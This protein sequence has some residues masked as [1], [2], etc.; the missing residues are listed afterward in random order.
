MDKL[1]ISKKEDFE[2]YKGK[3]LEPSPYIVIDQNRINEFADATNDHQWIHCDP[4]RAEKESP[5]GKTIAHGY[6]IVSLIPYMI[7]QIFDIQNY[8]EAINYEIINLKFM[9]PVPVNGEIRI[10]TE[11][12]NVK[13]IRDLT[14]VQFNVVVE[15][16]GSKQP[17][18]KAKLVYLYRF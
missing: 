13:Q 6:L 12:H 11:I 14:K 18:M 7:T 8:K 2:I 3:E 5:F 16:K 17:V 1:V 15:L 10:K 9:E 4:A